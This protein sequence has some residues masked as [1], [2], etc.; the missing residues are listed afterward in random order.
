M[1]V[2][3]RARTSCQAAWRSSR[4][5]T[6]NL[7]ISASLLT[8]ADHAAEDGG[9][10]GHAEKRSRP[11]CGIELHVASGAADLLVAAEPPVDKGVPCG[12]TLITLDLLPS[13]STL[14][15]LCYRINV[16]IKQTA[17]AVL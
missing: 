4:P 3:H 14:R 10:L 2:D 5:A 17:S 15:P 8:T 1:T 12:G 11:R 6:G 9:I 13:D 7:R 16:L